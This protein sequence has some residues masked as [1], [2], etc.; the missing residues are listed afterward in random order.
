M[1]T[2]DVV[3]LVADALMVLSAVV[4][5]GSVVLIRFLEYREEQEFRSLQRQ[6]LESFRQRCG[7]R[8]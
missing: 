1:S 5:L 2:F 4:A 7:A 8:A 6:R 3:I